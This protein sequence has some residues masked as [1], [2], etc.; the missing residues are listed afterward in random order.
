MPSST[1]SDFSGM[2]NGDIDKPSQKNPED[3]S[4]SPNQEHPTATSKSEEA[5]VSTTKNAP[6]PDPGSTSEPKATID[7]E[8]DPCHLLID[9]NG[10]RVRREWRELTKFQKQMY[11]DA[12]KEMFK[13]DQY[14]D[15][16]IWHEQP[17]IDEAAHASNA[18]LHWHRYFTFAR[19]NQ[20]RALGGNFRSVKTG[21]HK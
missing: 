12:N 10:L 9:E 8:Q 5:V 1:S 11:I 15:T 3:S 17:I 18:F 13:R 21:L 20:I 7:P 6:E 16:L 14:R 19:E 2:P 4:L